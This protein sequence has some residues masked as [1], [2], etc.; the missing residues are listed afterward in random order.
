MLDESILHADVCITSPAFVFLVNDFIN[1]IY[2]WFPCNIASS[3]HSESW[4]NTRVV[5]GNANATRV[6]PTSRVF[7]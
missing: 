5:L 3:K 6:L 4:E 7:R 2:N 1:D